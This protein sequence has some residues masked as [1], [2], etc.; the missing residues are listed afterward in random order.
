MQY[1]NLKTNTKSHQILCVASQNLS[2]ADWGLCWI[3]LRKYKFLWFFTNI[4]KQHPQC[5]SALDESLSVRNHSVTQI[6]RP[7]NVWEESEK[8]I[9]SQ[10]YVVV[11][12][13]LLFITGIS[14]SLVYAITLRDRWGSRMTL[15]QSLFT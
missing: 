4:Y 6:K 2:K 15:Q 9:V 5:R 8:L 10:T 11:F 14:A 7:V 3:G 12:L 1:P 13:S